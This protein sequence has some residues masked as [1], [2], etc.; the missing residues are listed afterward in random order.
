MPRIRAAR[1]GSAALFAAALLAACSGK[2][3]PAGER[4]RGAE[5]GKGPIV[6]GAPWP[7]EARGSIRYGDGMTLALEEV[8]AAGGVH[9]RRLEILRADDQE[10]VDRGRMVAQDLVKNPD[11]VAVIG[12]L[13]SYVTVPAAATYDLAGLVL[14]APTATSPELTGR[15]YR[16]VF[17]TTFSDEDVGHAMAD[18]ALKQGYRR[19]VIY[20][21]RDE[22]GRGLANAFEERATG[23][24]ARIL[25]RRS[26]D[27]SGSSG[28]LAAT[29]AAEAWRELDPDAVFIAGDGET[30]ARLAVALRAAGVNAPILGGDALAIPPYLEIGGAAVEGTVLPARFNPE[31]PTPQVREFREAFRRRFGV[32]PDVGA[33]LGYDAVH[34]LVNA[35]ARAPSVSPE[36]V[37]AALRSG[38]PW[39]G[40]TG[41]FRLGAHGELAES[42]I[43]KVVV[44]GGTFRHL[45]EGAALAAAPA[46]SDSGAP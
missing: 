32:E 13:Q 24:Q 2:D 29:E 3:D 46:P 15:G 17:R 45:D 44:R 10:D 4:A 39:E 25:D 16:R 33:A 30:G 12:H 19:V 36:A 8:N 40:V 5:K 26:Y 34:V 11:V 21:S 23:G 6:I 22:Y 20:Y 28:G 18:Y 43:R 35:M 31:T 7:W 38:P 41:T 37:A 27:L 14:L 42:P 1:L 9:G